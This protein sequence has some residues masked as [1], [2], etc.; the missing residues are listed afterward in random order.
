MA[1]YGR[2]CAERID[3]GAMD[4][5][6]P[7]KKLVRRW[8]MRLIKASASLTLRAFLYSPGAGGS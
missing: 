3:P 8:I 4:T 1:F 7:A 2:G 5:R 6:V